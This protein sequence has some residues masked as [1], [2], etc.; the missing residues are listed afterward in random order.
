MAFGANR[1]SVPQSGKEEQKKRGRVFTEKKGQPEL[2]QRTALSLQRQGEGGR[3]HPYCRYVHWARRFSH[4][5]IRRQRHWRR[6]LRSPT[7]NYGGDWYQ[8]NHR[9][10][11]AAE[12][13]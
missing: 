2:A 3:R 7:G 4:T 5:T 1:K 9:Q 12:I 8:P 10:H 6:T 13:N 11:G